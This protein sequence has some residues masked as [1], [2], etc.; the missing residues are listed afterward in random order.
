MTE[1]SIKSFWRA[2]ADLPS[3]VTVKAEH[4]IAANGLRCTYSAWSLLN[5]LFLLA[6]LCSGPHPFATKRLSGREPPWILRRLATLNYN[7]RAGFGALHFNE[8]N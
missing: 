1:S 8:D 7:Q 5:S 6:R 4:K 2:C 3:R